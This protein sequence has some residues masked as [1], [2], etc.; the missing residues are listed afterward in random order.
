MAQLTIYI[1][2]ELAERL[3]AKAKREGRSVSAFIVEITRDALAP[4]AWSQAFVDLYGSCEGEL[5]APDDAPPETQDPLW[6]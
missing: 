1:P 5:S 3:K 2:D 6:S 4:D